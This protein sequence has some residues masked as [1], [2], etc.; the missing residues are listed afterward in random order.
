VNPVPRQQVQPTLADQVDRWPA[1]VTNSFAGFSWD[2]MDGKPG[3][4]LEQIEYFT[5]FKAKSP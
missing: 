4:S 1:L 3:W 5:A 2:S